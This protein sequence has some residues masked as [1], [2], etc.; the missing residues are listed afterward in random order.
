[1]SDTRTR[2]TLTGRLTLDNFA[3]PSNA[4]I[5]RNRRPAGT[6]VVE[7]RIV[8]DANTEARLKAVSMASGSLS[9]SLYLERLVSQLEAERGSLPVL[10]FTRDSSEVHSTAAA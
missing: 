10:S 7:R 4:G 3:M 9:L 6:K 2:L 1:M 5:R 8:L